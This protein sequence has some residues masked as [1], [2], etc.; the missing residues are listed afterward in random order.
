MK[1]KEMSGFKI[2]LRLI[3]LVAPLKWIMLLGIILGSLGHLCA[4]YVTVFG[5]EG[6]ASIVTGSYAQFKNIIIALIIVA[7]A[8][9]VL[10]YGEQYCNHYI[11]FTVLA[12]IRHKVFDKLR[13][14]C[15][16]K[17]EGRDKGN[18]ITMLTTDIELL[19]VFFAHTISPIAI[20]FIVSVY[21]VIF[22]GSHSVIGGIIAA[23]AYIFIGVAVPLING[24]SS[25]EDGL[26]FRNEMGQ[27]NS[28]VLDLTYG[29]DESIQYNAYDRD[30]KYIEDESNRLAANQ[31]KLTHFEMNQ[32]SVTSIAIQFFS[33]LMLVAMAHGYLTGD[34][35][36]DQVVINQIAIMSSFGPVVALSSLSNNLNQT[37]ACGKR[38]LELLDEEPMVEDVKKGA[39]LV[40]GAEGAGS[41]VSVNN[42][43]FSYKDYEVLDNVSSEIMRE[44]ITGIHGPSGCGKSTFVKLLMRFWQPDN[45][46]IV[47]VSDG[48]IRRNLDV[49]NT[50]S[51]RDNQSYVSQETWIAHDSILNNIRVAKE[52]ASIEE[53]KEA[54]K[55]ANIYE[56][57]EG[58]DDGFDT[59]IGDG[60]NIISSGE[61]Q[62]IGLARAFLHDA[63][64]IILDEPTS[65]LD[66]LNESVI[67]KSIKNE[68]NH[69]TVLLVSHRDSTMKI[70][71]I[72]LEF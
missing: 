50:K 71:D 51:L 15:P 59:I 52:S 68:S 61:R 66:V 29:V 13:K 56:F 35:T 21:M 2:M 17:L 11:A 64:L 24:R 65:A 20:A 10:H 46:E 23:V 12:I 31:S 22:I 37:L 26:R 67:L 42:V 58:L 33:L 72:V 14:L 18:L 70:A 3:K 4:I 30:S 55:K 8:R 39:D 47:Y 62:R 7:I 60:D 43:S 44:K 27:F 40:I 34:Y 38:V 9:G 5:A 41:L 57:I 32:R 25:S 53:V 19:E 69:K 54:A 36:F 1:D 49:I 63:P 16:A 48:N 6:I 45:G 28:K